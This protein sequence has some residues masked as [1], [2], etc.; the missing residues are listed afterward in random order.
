MKSNHDMLHGGELNLEYYDCWAR[1]FCKFI[2]AYAKQGI[3]VWGVTV[4]NEPMAMQTW[5]SCNF[6]AAQERDFVKNDLGP[7]FK[8]NGLKKTKIIVWDHNRSFMYQYA[9]TILSDLARPNTCGAWAITG[10]WATIST[11]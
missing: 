1:Y 11:M 8:K 5:E 3:N 6:T 10:M 4:Q 9:S 7:E 2:H